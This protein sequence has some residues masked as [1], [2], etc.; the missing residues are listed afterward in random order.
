M[1]EVCWFNETD[2]TGYCPDAVSDSSVLAWW[3]FNNITG[4]DISGNNHDLTVNSNPKV[5]NAVFEKG[6]SLDGTDDY[7][8]TNPTDFEG[9]S[10]VTIIGWVKFNDTTPNPV[11]IDV[12]SPLVYIIRAFTGCGGSEEYF[13]VIL[14]ANALKEICGSTSL[15]IDTWYHYAMTY[16]SGND[17][18]VKLYIN[19]ILD[20]ESTNT[21]GNTATST[22]SLRLGTDG[23][24]YLNGSMD[25]TRIYNVALTQTQIQDIYYQGK[26][27]H[28][29]LGEIETPPTTTTTTTIPISNNPPQITIYSPENITYSTNSIPINVMI[30][31]DNSPTFWVKILFNDYLI[32]N[33]TNYVNDSNFNDYAPLL[34]GVWNITIWANDMD[35]S[36]PLTAQSEIFFTVNPPPNILSYRCIGNY[37]TEVINGI[38]NSSLYCPFGCSEENSINWVA[39]RT[40]QGDICNQDPFFIVSIVAVV[41]TAFVVLVLYIRKKW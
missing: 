34:N 9:L 12:P 4:T 27:N 17:G 14:R 36:D 23:D 20:G 1:E 24:D 26:G 6:W 19:G 10:A 13:N 32:Y 8:S 3:N 39:G 18:K 7:G 28:T 37:S 29:H 5:D 16:D 21:A 25:D 22:N 2:G 11:I 40:P 15:S 41:I 33:D 35:I 38:D 30:I 31:D